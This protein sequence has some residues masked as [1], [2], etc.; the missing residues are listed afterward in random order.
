LLVLPGLISGCSVLSPEKTRSYVQYEVKPGDTL[1]SIGQR[2]NVSV[3]EL[4][5]I[6]RIRDVRSLAA[7][8]VIRVPSNGETGRGRRLS[9]ALNLPM[10]RSSQRTV[11]LAPVKQYVGAMVFPLPRGT[12]RYSSGFSWRRSS[13]HEGMDLAALEGTPVYAAHAGRVIYSSNG[14]NGYGKLIVIRGEGL[15]TVYA[16]NSRLRVDAGEQVEKGEVISEVGDTGNARGFHLHFET[17]VWD[18]DRQ[19]YV[20]VDPRVFYRS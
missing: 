15:L 6:N 19:G 7:G 12:W 8:Q 17:R 5:S 4:Q 14:L 3:S 2:Y 11:K 16:H 18:A 20:A 1:Y 10:Q 13:F 9:K